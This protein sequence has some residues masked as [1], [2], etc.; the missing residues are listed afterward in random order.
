[1]ESNVRMKVIYPCTILHIRKYLKSKAFKITETYNMYL[2]K[3]LPFIKSLP[4][5]RTLWV[6]KI[7]NK[8]AE[9][10]DVI[11]LDED[12]KDGFVLLPDSKWDRTNMT[13]MYLLAISKC[14]IICIRELS[15]DHIPLLKN[16]KSK[17]EEI[18]KG[19]YGIE[20]DQL[21]MFVHYHPSYYHFHVHI[22][23]CDVE[24]TKA[25]IAGHSHL[26]DDIIDLL[27]IDSNIFKNRALT[28]YLNESH[29]LLTLLKRQE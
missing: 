2:E 26:L 11:I 1:M 21:R 10:D 7:L 22:V 27:S 16:I 17:T 13:N 20:A 25:M 19:K 12:E 4:E 14:P 18:V 28:F 23:H 5:E 3:T 15:S 29:P 24:P 9:Q 6:T 8:Q